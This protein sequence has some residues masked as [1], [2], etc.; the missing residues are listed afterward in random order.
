MGAPLQTLS[1]PDLGVRALSAFDLEKTL[2]AFLKQIFLDAWRLDNPGVNLLQESPAHPIVPPP[3]EG[4]VPFDPEGRMLTLAGKVPPQIVRGYV[5]TDIT[6]VID[7]TK[8][9]DVPA[10]IVNASQGKIQNDQTIVTVR[11]FFSGYDE[12]PDGSGYQDVLNM[13]E[14]TAIAL[15][16]WGQRGIDDA[17]PIIMPIEWTRVHMQMAPH[18]FA[19]M[20]TTWQLP[21]ARPLPD[22]GECFTP[23]EHV[24]ANITH[25][26]N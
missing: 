24:T 9:P 7:P 1:N 20:T 5:P 2:V 18:F 4:T 15:T 8:L 21:S 22:A 14:A 13:L 3:P 16:S 26:T 25:E 23:A 19:E 11:L 6:G 12:N 17:Y 10:I